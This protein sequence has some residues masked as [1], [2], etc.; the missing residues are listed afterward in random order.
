[1]SVFDSRSYV[2][3]A[4]SAN[5]A[6]QWFIHPGQIT[7]IG[8]SAGRVGYLRLRSAWWGLA[9]TLGF[10]H[11]WANRSDLLSSDGLSYFDIATAYL[12][13]DW[14]H[15][16]NAYWSP[17]YSWLLAA[18]LWI[19][20]PSAYWELSVMRLV[21]WVIFLYAMACFDFLMR[22]FLRWRHA[23]ISTL[24]EEMR[25][26]P[27]NWVFL[28]LGYSLFIWFTIF[29]IK[30]PQEHPDVLLSGFIYLI[31]GLLLRIQR[32]RAN[33]AV[34]VAL[35]VTLGIGYLAKA[36]MVPLACVFVL[37]SL[38]A[39]GK[40]TKAFP[41]ALLAMVVF[42]FVAAPFMIALSQS[43]GRLTYGETGKLNYVWSV[44]LGWVSGEY[45]TLYWEKDVPFIGAPVHPMHKVYEEPAIYE[46]TTP[47]GGTYPPWYDPSYWYEGLHPRVELMGQVRR[48]A[49]SAH[50]YYQ[51]F[52]STAQFGLLIAVL[53]L[54]LV[55]ND[56][57]LRSV[58]RHWVLILPGLV[59]MG[60][61]SLVWMEPRYVATFLVI[62]W[63]GLF[64]GVRLSGRWPASELFTKMVL[65]V[66]SFL[67]ILM[68]GSSAS[69]IASTT[70]ALVR[71]E[72]VAVH[73]N[74]QLANEL[75]LTGAQ[76]GESL[77]ILGRGFHAY[78]ARLAGMKIVAEIPHP[79]AFWGADEETKASVRQIL[80]KYG[81]K[82]LVAREIPIHTDKTG[83]RQ[84]GTTGYFIYSLAR[85]TQPNATP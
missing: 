82:Y 33:W 24:P 20:N 61:Y 75:K 69:E 23:K 48:L 9:A 35:G 58:C 64:S 16:I 3:L 44:N 60:M 68:I 72:G 26:D 59:A 32:G 17:L 42:L 45:T 46:F 18:A 13:G 77:A 2:S 65:S 76:S 71:G 36:V 39:V 41:R 52:F 22:E 1:M 81:A 28:I 57:R 66:T 49:Y 56:G 83:W 7:Q 12:R 70:Q 21:N 62:L 5:L 85:D 50:G 84:A 40:V 10:A 31:V 43:K 55:E 37:M 8:A 63:L 38:F 19:F 6:F 74:W 11:A 78:W 4:R 14:A 15:A 80:T 54:Y 53:F 25:T 47:V 30:I 67:F 29:Q 73:Q 79:E 51:F 34:F 27:P